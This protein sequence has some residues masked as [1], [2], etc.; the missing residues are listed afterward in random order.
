MNAIWHHYLVILS[1]PCGP[2]SRKR[3]AKT[4]ARL[5]H[6][7]VVH[8]YDIVETE[9]SDG[10]VMELVGGQTLSARM[11]ESNQRSIARSYRPSGSAR[12]WRRP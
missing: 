2:R 1:D 8:V 10:I 7:A 5:N 9:A 11:R 4:A 12:P 3:S 6:P